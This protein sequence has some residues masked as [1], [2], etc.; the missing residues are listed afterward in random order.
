M[1]D[2]PKIDHQEL[3]FGIANINAPV[4]IEKPKLITAYESA[5]P[6]PCVATVTASYSW[7]ITINFNGQ[8]KTLSRSAGRGKFNCEK[9]GQAW[10]CP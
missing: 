1:R 8:R 4:P 3:S 9:T 7:Q 2:P 5:F 6:K 10:H